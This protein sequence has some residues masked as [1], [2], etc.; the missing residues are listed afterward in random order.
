MTDDHLNVDANGSNGHPNSVAAVL[1]SVAETLRESP[2]DKR[3]DFTLQI[4][5]LG[6]GDA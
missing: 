5:E 4:E 1:E 3:Y 2:D 6:G